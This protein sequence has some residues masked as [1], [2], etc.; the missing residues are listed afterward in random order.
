M[1]TTMQTL[2]PMTDEW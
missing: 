1:T 2:K